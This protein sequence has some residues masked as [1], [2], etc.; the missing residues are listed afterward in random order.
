MAYKTPMDI[1]IIATLMTFILGALILAS[2]SW[3]RRE[4]GLGLL[5]A[6]YAQELLSANSAASVEAAY[7]N[8]K[9]QQL[10]SKLALA[11][12]RSEEQGLIQLKSDL[13]SVLKVG[14]KNF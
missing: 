8:P 3:S 6:E 13:A 4:R 11:R 10:A 9:L 1:K 2:R 5:E 7:Q 12:G 14:P